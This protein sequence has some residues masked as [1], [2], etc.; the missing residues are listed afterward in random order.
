MKQVRQKIKLAQ[1]PS[2]PSEK[3]NSNINPAVETS[4]SPKRKS[5]DKCDSVEASNRPDFTNS[6]KVRTGDGETAASSLPPVD[7]SFTRPSQDRSF[8]LPAEFSKDRI[9]QQIVDSKIKEQE[10]RLKSIF[11]AGQERL[12]KAMD[13][14]KTQNAPLMTN[15]AGSRETMSLANASFATAASDISL[16]SNN[17]ASAVE[18]ASQPSLAATAADSVATGESSDSFERSDMT[19]NAKAISVTS[20]AKDGKLVNQSKL[21]V[22]EVNLRD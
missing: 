21:P 15:T 2:V 6:K 5:E 20:P 14:M 8:L 9:S 4:R 18:A 7:S 3:A 10:E 16:I 17:N 19:R 11:N 12:R 22:P 13:S 1:K